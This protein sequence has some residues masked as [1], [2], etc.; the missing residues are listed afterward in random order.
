VSS[1]VFE[2]Q[3]ADAMAQAALEALAAKKARASGLLR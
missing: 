3:Q 2:P 1:V